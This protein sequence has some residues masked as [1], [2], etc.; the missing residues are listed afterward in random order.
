MSQPQPARRKMDSTEAVK[1]ALVIL[2]LLLGCVLVL[3]LATHLM[4]SQESQPNPPPQPADFQWKDS[5]PR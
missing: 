3:W 2:G 1:A 4:N 5:A